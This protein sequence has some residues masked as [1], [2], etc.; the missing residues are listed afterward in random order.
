MSGNVR[1]NSIGKPSRRRL[2]IPSQ[3]G[4]AFSHN[5]WKKISL[6]YT[7]RAGLRSFVLS[8]FFTLWPFCHPFVILVVF[9]ILKSPPLSMPFTDLSRTSQP[10]PSYCPPRDQAWPCA[11]HK[12]NFRVTKRKLQHHERWHARVAIFQWTC[13]SPC[14]DLHLRTELPQLDN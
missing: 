13:Q 2:N 12:L 7:L 8:S 14:F 4:P 11:C 3:R 6:D 9:V 10:L 1:L 5:S